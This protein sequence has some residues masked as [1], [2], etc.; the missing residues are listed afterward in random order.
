[1]SVFD[2]IQGLK[3]RLL[4]NN[5]FPIIFNTQKRISSF[6]KDPC[7]SNSVL[8]WHTYFLTV[9]KCDILPSNCVLILPGLLT[10]YVVVRFDIFLTLCLCF[11]LYNSI[12][13]RFCMVYTFPLT[14]YSYFILAFYPYLSMLYPYLL[15]VCLVL[16]LRACT[17]HTQCS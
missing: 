12:T 14:V 17:L 7:E 5:T 8:T 9:C 10:V 3:G 13:V 6:K 15:T 16:T 2:K 1:V 11:I 4:R